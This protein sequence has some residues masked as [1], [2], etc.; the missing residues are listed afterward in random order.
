MHLTFHEKSEET[1][2]LLFLNYFKVLL[3]YSVVWN[4]HRKIWTVS[5]EP[6]RYISLL[7]LENT[8]T[9]M[10]LKNRLN[11]L[12]HTIWA[13]PFELAIQFFRQLITN[14]DDYIQRQMSMWHLYDI[15][16]HLEEHSIR[17]ANF[18]YIVVLILD[19]YLQI[20]SCFIKI[21]NIK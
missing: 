14:L 21:Q 6:W 12:L 5:L 10:R 3:F 13:W 16:H 1:L 9:R 17:L 8:T 19:V 2:L 11:I 15:L 7:K 4:F 20:Y 18:R